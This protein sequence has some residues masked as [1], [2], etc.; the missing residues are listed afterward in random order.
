MA[1]QLDVQ[2]EMNKLLKERTAFL[3]EQSDLMSA[4]VTTASAIQKAWEG[5]SPKEITDHIA[6]LNK[7]LE[8]SA[9]KFE[10]TGATG[11]TSNAK[12]AK[13]VDKAG[14]SV[15]SMSRTI[16][17]MGRKRWP[18][19]TAAA[20]GF[21]SGLI[22][23]FKYVTNVLRTS[24]GLVTSIAEGFLDVTASIVAIPFR[25]LDGLVAVAS[26]LAGLLQ[27]IATATEEV[28]KQFGALSTG[29]AKAILTTSKAVG[30][31]WEDLGLGGYQVFGNL[32]ERIRFVNQTATEMGAVF[33]SFRGEF[34]DMGGAILLMQKGLGLTGEEMKGLAMRAKA[35]GTTMMVQLKE[36]TKFSRAFGKTFDVS[37][38][39]ISRDMGQMV[40]DVRNFG[41]LAPKE[42][43][44]V[45]VY[46]RRLG[47]DVKDLLGVVDKFDTFEDAATSA[48]MLSQAFGVQVDAIKLMNA[49]NPA[50][51]VDMLR[52][53]FLATGQSADK[54][55]RQEL[56][57]LSTITGLSE[58]TAKAAFSQKNLGAS[59]ADLEKQG[60]ITE[61]RQLST[62]EAVQLL[63][64]SIERMI[65]AFRPFTGFLQ[66]FA[67]GFARGVF[68]AEPMRDLLTAIY[69]ALRQ[70]YRIGMQ[71]GEAFVKVFPKITDVTSALN[72]LF[73]VKGKD[74]P[75][76]KFLKSVKE[77]FIDF[78]HA[79]AGKDPEAVPNLMKKLKSEFFAWFDLGGKGRDLYNKVKGFVGGLGEVVAGL[80]DVLAVGVQTGISDL[81]TFIE[82]GKFGTFK[83]D[84]IVSSFLTPIKRAFEDNWENVRD[85]LVQLFEF[86]WEKAKPHVKKV[87]MDVLPWIAGIMLGSAAIQ[88]FI[89]FASAKLSAAIW[90]MLVQS[91]TTAVASGGAA[92]GGSALGGV[93]ASLAA[94]VFDPLVW[95]PAAIAAVAGAAVGVSRG[96]KTFKESFDAE[97]AETD[98]MVGAA[99]AGVV[100][101]LTLG[102]VSDET[103]REIGVSVARMSELFAE[104]V[105]KMPLG[106]SLMES[107]ESMIKSTVELWSS[108]GDL[109]VALWEGDSARIGE[110]FKSFGEKATGHI[111]TTLQEMGPILLK[112]VLSIATVTGI[113][114][115]KGLAF[116]LTDIIP[117]VM[118]QVSLLVGGAFNIIA[119]AFNEVGK[120]IGK[121]PIIG[122]LLEVPFKLIGSLFEL[123]G[124]VFIY[125]GNQF[126]QLLK[127]SDYIWTS[128]GAQFDD[129]AKGFKEIA[130]GISK[131]VSGVFSNEEGNNFIMAWIDGIDKGVRNLTGVVTGA[132]DSAVKA[133]KDFLG[134]ASPSKVFIG[135]GEDIISG[136]AMGFKGMGSAVVDGFKDTVTHAASKGL[137]RVASVFEG[138][139]VT[140]AFKDF[141]SPAV[142]AIGQMID[143]ANAIND[144]LANLP[145]V[146]I[147]VKLKQLADRLGLKG[148][149]FNVRS[150]KVNLLVNLD[151]NIE[152]DKL[153]K[154][155]SEHGLISTQTSRT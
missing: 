89:S 38:K 149:Q 54:F 28:R 146:D 15:G 85:S 23:G 101:T 113:A 50:E 103:A 116:T 69:N 14:A 88:G 33:E 55:N 60:K 5:A 82:T 119:G 45:S 47:I 96:M 140:E 107:I 61:K 118:K 66:A 151:I 64:E 97:F 27:E 110:A 40:K 125:L 142:E 79:I 53:A 76:K 138:S 16:D 65:K 35:T 37:A 26:K 12:V 150:D 106:E 58:E 75:F 154:V 86:A 124:S 126:D 108:F 36:L 21:I 81:I 90:T 147:K 73:S 77:S 127:Y 123:I 137:D 7:A 111:I 70:T 4:Q 72:D 6:E 74:A 104:N 148:E 134:I 2:R 3:Q 141:T 68:M 39:L 92:A 41:N 10:E 11:S 153:V 59:M 102:L 100:S 133:V 25:V 63:N 91:T 144:S 155:L 9:K 20:L 152:A 32:A 22:S 84:G 52:Q 95:I 94:I 117:W 17:E 143:E 109:L 131:W 121:I 19:A 51:R 34:D 128:I 71:V 1:S 56:K 93:G 99:V 130:D 139:N 18:A 122:P 129:F 44:K 48:A 105:R 49:E 83:G 57:Y 67:D 98:A 112:T 24:V 145:T 42:L 135:I 120:F 80:G 46:A 8:D 30:K 87:A 62:G 114:L 31:G 136:V 29:P 115:L 78:F 132:V 43:A 13:A